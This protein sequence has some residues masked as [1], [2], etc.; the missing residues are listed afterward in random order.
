MVTRWVVSR[1]AALRKFYRAVGGI[2]ER[3]CLNAAVSVLNGSQPRSP[4]EFVVAAQYRRPS[5]EETE[6]SQRARREYLY[7][8]LDQ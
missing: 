3:C 1:R 6:L 2:G 4:I 5:L 8:T 7:V